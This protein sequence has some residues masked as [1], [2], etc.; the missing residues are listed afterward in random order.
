LTGPGVILL[1]ARAEQVLTCC[2]SN[3]LETYTA[4]ALG[5]VRCLRT[6]TAL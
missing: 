6:E 5:T 3:M 2:N 1:R 4:G